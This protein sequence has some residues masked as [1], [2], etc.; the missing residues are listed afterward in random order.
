MR[1]GFVAGDAEILKKYLLYRTY[2]GC[3]MSPPIH[4]ASIAA[5]RDEDHVREN[6]R[7]YREKF[8]AAMKILGKTSG[9]QM[10]DAGFYLWIDTQRDDS[11]FTRELYEQFHV[12]VLPGSYLAR[13]ARGI[14]PGRNFVRVALVAST[15]ECSE[16]AQRI[17]DFIARN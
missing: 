13:E 12:T 7:L 6:R 10:P 15:A 4:A 1:S 14:N 17:A 16:A 9:V 3:A 5:W 2:Q 8:E 11:Q